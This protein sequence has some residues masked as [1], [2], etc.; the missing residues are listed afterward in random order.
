M[1]MMIRIS[2]FFIYF[3]NSLSCASA[4]VG[5]FA[6]F[7]VAWHLRG[8][9]MCQCALVC[10]RALACLA[11]ALARVRPRGQGNSAG[12]QAALPITVCGLAMWRIFRTKFQ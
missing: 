10:P 12:S 1:F 2:I 11:C 5:S 8:K 4:K 9:Q 3:F 7:G 6:C